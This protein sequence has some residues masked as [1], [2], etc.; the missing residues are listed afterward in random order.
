M[1]YV[2]IGS[3]YNFVLVKI[4]FKLRKVKIGINNSKRFDVIKFKDLVVRE[5]F[6]IIFRNRYSVFFE[7][8]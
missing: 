3:D 5:E 4:R 1:R 8:R 7:M 6:N 2:D